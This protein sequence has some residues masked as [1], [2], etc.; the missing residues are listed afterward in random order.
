MSVPPRLLDA[1]E[2]ALSDAVGLPPRNVVERVWL[3]MRGVRM[4]VGRPDVD[5]VVK[6]LAFRE[7][8]AGK[9]L[10]SVR[11]KYGLGG[12]TAQRMRVLVTALGELR[13]GEDVAAVCRRHKFRAPTRER[14]LELL[15]ETNDVHDHSAR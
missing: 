14:L 13:G 11:A 9:S 7:M 4:P 8:L 15:K 10:R 5:P 12:A 2:A 1:G 6:D 3:A